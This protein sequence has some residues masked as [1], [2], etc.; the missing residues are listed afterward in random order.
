[1]CGGERGQTHFWQA[2]SVHSSYQME[3]M[4]TVIVPLIGGNDLSG[5][6]TSMAE[7][8]AAGA[9]QEYLRS[10]HS[11]VL[12]QGA[13]GHFNMTSEPYAEHLRRYLVCEGV[14]PEDILF[15]PK[16][17]STV[18]EAASAK[19]FLAEF[20]GVS[21]CV[22]TSQFHMERASFVFEH[23]FPRQ[24]LRFVATPNAITDEELVQREAHEVSAMELL[25]KQGGVILNGTLFRSTTQ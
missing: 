23:F 18:T 11:K 22:V 15:N 21:V 2:T 25:R 14:K 13:F 9:V 3:E 17:S 5:S 1:M 4:S 24:S 12:A 7:S 20:P 16:A 8:R 6:L 10:K 19:E